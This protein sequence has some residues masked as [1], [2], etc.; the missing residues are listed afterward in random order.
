MQSADLTA[1]S[2]PRLT[3]AEERIRSGL[4]SLSVDP[5]SSHAARARA[6]ALIVADLTDDEEMLDGT[7]LYSLIDSGALAA[8]KALS[9]KESNSVRIASELMRLG[10]FTLATPTRTPG[11]LSPNQAEALRKMLLAIVTDPRLV[12]IKLAV[13]LH[14]LRESKD[15][16]PAER[17]QIAYEVREIYAPLAN[18]LGVWQVKWEL[19]DLSFRF[20][21]PEN[22]KRVAGWLAAKRVDR[23]RYIEDV[24]AQLQAELAKAN[25]KA[26][27]A[28]RPKHIYSIWKKMQRKGLSFDQLYDIRAVRVLVDSI[29]DCY[30]A[31]GV[32]HGLWSYIPGEFDDYIAT[33]KDNLYRSLH[34]AVIGPGK[35]P[36]EIQIRTF[37]M[38]EHAELGVAAHWRYKEG[39]RAN[40]AYEQKIVW[41]RQILEPG[42]KDA[43]TDGDFLERVRS[44]VFEDRVYALSPRGEVVDLP[45]GATPLDFAYHLH[46]DLGHRCRGAKVNGRMVPLNQQL[47]N[48]DQVEIITGKQLNPSRDW[49]VPSLG[50]LASPRNRSKV[51]AWFRKLDE[52]QNRQ[53]GRQ[54]LERE[55]QRLAIHSVSLPELISEFNFTNAEQLYQAIGEGEVNA[56]QISGA[57]LRRAKP[58]E[59]PSPVPRKPAARPKDTAGI[60]IEG[61]GDLLSNFARCCGPVPPEPIAGYIT[62][63]RGVSIHR[64]DCPNLKRLHTAHPE[65]VIAVE[66]G[67]ASDRAFPVDVNVRAF[68]R[69]GLLRDISAV[70]ADS[71]INIH[72]MNTVTHEGDGVADM[73]LR[74]T[75]QDLEELSRVLA[76]LQG[77]PNVLS[78]RRRV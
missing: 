24:K 59:L 19:E 39:G 67:A 8:E 76:R 27:V 57:I 15:A 65:R 28:G 37:E 47:Q 44:E 52:E 77:L 54:I 21:E 13:E 38:H 40:P 51:R 35:L 36:L 31:L 42:E 45:R 48:G 63:G 2:N 23:E 41:L 56:A 70:L 25:I 61:V 46:T 1:D 55:L 26:D 69:R 32:V 3:R 33:P 62:L 9:N 30:A 64:E 53:Q 43:E 4:A 50:Y 74:I 18:R 12:L 14:R 34:T 71:K 16:P 73:N 7:L 10:T 6:I 68:D 22:Y 72:A 60:T 20:L 78:A 58:Q 29:A 75:V 11:G 17:E 5:S 66:W 49:L